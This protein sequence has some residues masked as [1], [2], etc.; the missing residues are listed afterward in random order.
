MD[1]LGVFK[2]RRVGIVTRGEKR[3]MYAM[4]SLYDLCWR[5][6]VDSDENEFW[7]LSR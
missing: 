7:I 1:V 2:L 6:I 4:T 5:S 3:H